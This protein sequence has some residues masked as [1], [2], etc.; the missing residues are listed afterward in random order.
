MPVY[1]IRHPRP[2]I[3]DG[4]CYG[5][6]DVD[7]E[8]PAPVARQLRPLLPSR[9]PIISSPLRRERRLA[10]ALDPAM[11]VD[12]RLA[13]ISFGEWEGRSWNDIGR[14]QID[15][16][17]DDVLHFR[18]PGGESVADLQTRVGE[19]ARALD[20]QPVAIVAH[21]GVLRALAGYWR[22]LPLAEWSQLDFA[23]GSLTLIEAF[24]EDART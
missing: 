10:E 9:M 5:Q 16:W 3:A 17:A 21:A 1:L 11:Q 20:G 22:R 14:T 12:R 23:F 2:L 19:F 6:L 4:I 15:A 24:A 18:P 7:C 8:D 13:E